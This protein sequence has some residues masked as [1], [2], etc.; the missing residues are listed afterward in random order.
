MKVVKPLKIKLGD[1]KIRNLKFTLLRYEQKI[2]DF[3]ISTRG[4]FCRNDIS[5]WVSA[6]SVLTLDPEAL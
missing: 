3:Q 5:A 6:D 2:R 4:A 1:K